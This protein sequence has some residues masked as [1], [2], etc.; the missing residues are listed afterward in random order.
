MLHDVSQGIACCSCCWLLVGLLFLSI[1]KSLSLFYTRAD[2]EALLI[3][4]AVNTN[5]SMSAAP[6]TPFSADAMVATASGSIKRFKRVNAWDCLV[7]VRYGPSNDSSHLSGSAEAIVFAGYDFSF[8][9]VGSERCADALGASWPN[10]EI[11]L[12]FGVSTTAVHSSWKCGDL[13]YTVC[14]NSLPD[15]IFGGEK[16]CQHAF[17]RRPREDAR[18]TYISKRTNSECLAPLVP[19]TQVSCSVDKAGQVRLGTK[20][21][22][23]KQAKGLVSLF[24]VSEL[25]LGCAAFVSLCISLCICCAS[26][27]HEQWHRSCCRQVRTMSQMSRGDGTVELGHD[28]EAEHLQGAS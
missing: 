21:E 28:N 22:Q 26:L 9:D 2:K 10:I 3:S 18:T 8:Q 6:G 23:V 4:G 13:G 12:P 11:R 5:C 19:G 16:E 1:S 25:G 17:G 15:S 24:H 20:D 27:G 14:R 7:T